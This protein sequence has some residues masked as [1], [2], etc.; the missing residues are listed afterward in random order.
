[1]EDLQ[2]EP[3]TARN[4]RYSAEKTQHVITSQWQ[5]VANESMEDLGRARYSRVQPGTVLEVPS[6]AI[7][8]ERYQG[9]QGY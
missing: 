7:F 4:S 5:S 9:F 2:A 6:C 3:G 1:M 8:F